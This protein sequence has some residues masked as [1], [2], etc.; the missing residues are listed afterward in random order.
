MTQLEGPSSERC[1][2]STSPGGSDLASLPGACRQGKVARV[3]SSNKCTQPCQVWP[4][5]SN[6]NHPDPRRLGANRRKR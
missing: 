5:K 6:I 4:V 1:T 3:A 2:P